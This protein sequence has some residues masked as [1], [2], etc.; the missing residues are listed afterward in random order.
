MQP[1]MPSESTIACITWG[2]VC[3][4]FLPRLLTMSSPAKTL[5]CVSLIQN[6]P[7]RMETKICVS[8]NSNIHKWC[9]GLNRGILNWNKVAENKCQA[10]LANRQ[11]IVPYKRIKLIYSIKKKEKCTLHKTLQF[12]KKKE[13]ESSTERDRQT[14]KC[15]VSE[16]SPNINSL[17][18]HKVNV[19]W[20]G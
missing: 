4:G 13:T 8:T 6:N 17:P 19:I 20:S 15:T 1:I 18:P 7:P 16:F 3:R 9:T 14:D 5:F 10:F 2:E 11:N 12:K